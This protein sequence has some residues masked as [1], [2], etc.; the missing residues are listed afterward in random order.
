M[1]V[2]VSPFSPLPIDVDVFRPSE[3][4]TSESE[5][6]RPPSISNTAGRKSTSPPIPLILRFHPEL[7]SFHPWLFIFYT[8]M[9][10]VTSQL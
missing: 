7:L 2:F 9:A 10:I 8:G 3:V 5:E 6:N 1:G 4:D